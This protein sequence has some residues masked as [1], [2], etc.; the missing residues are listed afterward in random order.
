MMW[1]D[2]TVVWLVRAWRLFWLGC[3]G[4]AGHRHQAP[5]RRC[6]SSGLRPRARERAHCSPSN[7]QSPAQLTLCPIARNLNGCSPPPPPAA[8]SRVAVL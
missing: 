7:T 1:I 5:S 2:L 8:A 6:H 3:V 4:E